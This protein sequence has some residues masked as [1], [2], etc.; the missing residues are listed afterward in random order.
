MSADIRGH[1]ATQPNLELRALYRL[2]YKGAF[3]LEI[4]VRAQELCES[5]GGRHGLPVPNN[6]YGLCGGETKE[7]FCP[8]KLGQKF[9]PLP[10]FIVEHNFLRHLFDTEPW[11]YIYASRWLNQRCSVVSVTQG[12]LYAA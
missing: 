3:P 5:G 10:A 9:V 4:Q 2:S 8:K 12:T 7:E 11:S 1:Q 6:P